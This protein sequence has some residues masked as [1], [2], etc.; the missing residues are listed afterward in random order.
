MAE[1]RSSDRGLIPRFCKPVYLLYGAL[2]G[3]PLL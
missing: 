1:D 2:G 3:Q